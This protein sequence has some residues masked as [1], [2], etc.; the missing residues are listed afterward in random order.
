MCL[1]LHSDISARMCKSSLGRGESD[2][3]SL[4]AGLE[5]VEN[6][7]FGLM[8]QLLLSCLCLRR[9]GSK[10]GCSFD[11]HRMNVGR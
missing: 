4:R 9:A 6:M 1:L 11:E 7:F 10:E 2:A 5:S 3:A 8:K